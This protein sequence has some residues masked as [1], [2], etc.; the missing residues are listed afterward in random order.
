MIARTIIMKGLAYNT[1][2][3]SNRTIVEEIRKE[4]KMLGILL[5]DHINTLQTRQKKFK[6]IIPFHR[7]RKINFLVI[8][9]EDSQT[10]YG[11]G[12]GVNRITPKLKLVKNRGTYV[13][14]EFP[15]IE[16]CLIEQLN[17]G[18][19]K[20]NFCTAKLHYFL[21]LFSIEIKYKLV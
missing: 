19:K 21:V 3:R 5:K 13:V 18:Y 8:Y 17:K 7:K 2:Y 9:T 4:N 10:V 12:S 14:W 15:T 6:Y 1:V 16:L 11:F 20:L